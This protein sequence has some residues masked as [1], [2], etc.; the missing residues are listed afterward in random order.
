MKRR[1]LISIIATGTWFLGATLALAGADGGHDSPSGDG[2]EPLTQMAVYLK[3]DATGTGDGTCWTNAHTSV[4]NALYDAQAKGLPVYAAQGVYI[5]S[6][7]IPLPP[8]FA[9]YGG[10]PGLSMDETPADRAP[11][12]CQTIFS[13][14][15][16]QDDVWEHYEPNTSYGLDTTTLE[17]KVIVNGR[18][19]EPPPFTG[20]YDGY[21]PVLKGSNT[22]VAFVG[23]SSYGVMD[24]V[25]V[26]GFTTAGNSTTTYGAINLVSAS[27]GNYIFDNCRF[28]GNSTHYGVFYMRNSHAAKIWNCDF[29]YNWAL[30]RCG[31]ITV[32]SGTCGDNITN[33]T[34]LCIARTGADAGLVLNGWSGGF[35]VKDSR[36]VRCVQ[37]SGG[38][39]QSLYG[40]AGAIYCTE[41]G[42]T[43]YLLDCV[44]TN[45]FVATSNSQGPSFFSGRGTVH[46][47]R[48]LF[49]NNLA[50]CKPTAGKAFSMI[51]NVGDAGEA[52]RSFE[53][54]TFAG[55]LMRA[56][57]VAV[58]A[59]SYALGIIGNNVQGAGSMLL[60]CTFMTNMAET[61]VEKEGVT[62]V[63]C[64]GVLTYSS[65]QGQVDQTGLANCTFLGP[66]NGQYDIAQYGATHGYPLNIV[67][68]IFEADGDVQPEPVY[69]DV[70]SLVSFYNSSILNKFSTANESCT[71]EGLQFDKIPLVQDIVDTHNGRWALRPSAMVPGL[72][73]TCNVA[74]NGSTSYGWVFKRTTADATWQALAPNLNALSGSGF[75]ARLVDDAAG[76][77]RPSGSFTRGVLQTL[78]PTAEQGRSLVLRRDPYAGG[79]F[80]E[81]A[82]QSVAIG[83]DI[84]PVTA[85]VTDPDLYELDG[86]YLTNGT[87]V[88]TAA[89]LSGTLA[90]YLTDP[91]TIIVCKFEAAPVD[92]TLDLG[93]AGQFVAS[94]TS[95][96]TLSLT[97]GD[98]FPDIPAWTPDP[99]WVLEGFDTPAF[100]PAQATTYHARVVSSAVRIIHLVPEA[101]APAV[102]D[103][104]SW[105]TAYT[106]LATAYADAGRYRGEVWIK[107]GRYFIGTAVQMIPNVAVRGGFAGNETSADAADPASNLTILTGDR[108]G[109][110]YWQPNGS[111]DAKFASYRIWTN[112]V[113]GAGWTFNPPNPN[114][115]HN[116]W[117][118]GGNN[119]DDAATLFANS[120]ANCTNNLL[121]GLV[122]T[123]FRSGAIITSSGLADGFTA[124][125]CRFLAN[126][127]GLDG[128]EMAGVIRCS[129][130][131]MT[132]K[133]C[134]FHGN[135]YSVSA[136]SSS[137][138][139]FRFENCEFRDCPY[140]GSYSAGAFRMM[141]RACAIA[142]NTLF[143]R[144]WCGTAGGQGAA[145][146]S[147]RSTATH[148]FDDC[149]FEENRNTGDSHG[150]ICFSSGGSDAVFNR[151]KF[152]RNRHDN[153]GNSENSRGAC[154]GYYN[155][156]G[157]VMLRDCWFE[158]NYVRSTV[159]GDN[160]Y[161]ASV[162]SAIYGN[163]TFVNSTFLSN[164]N[165]TTQANICGT[166]ST[167]G[168]VAMINCAFKDTCLIG[169]S[170]ADVHVNGTPTAAIINTV[171]A[172]ELEGYVPLKCAD[173]NWVL[174]VANA[175]MQNLV[176]NGIAS[177]GSGYFYNVSTNGNPGFRARP[178]ERQGVSAFGLRAGSPY[179]FA[180]RPVW[181]SG[182]T[183][184][185]Y[186]DIHDAA[187]PW[188]KAIDR[189][190]TAA[191]V[192]GL[193]LQ[194][195]RIPDAF[196]RERPPRG[197]AYGPLNAPQ[198]G[199]VM[200]L[201]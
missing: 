66:Q 76:V 140:S 200:L 100:V 39:Y 185:F 13:G 52:Y 145:A 88:S 128:G 130:S 71:Y 121:D 157:T 191:S 120:S 99:A 83:D 28:V 158:G 16:G 41:G 201:R 79:T 57:E 160:Q 70:P 155:G 55:N 48:C 163:T 68:C 78:T 114:D 173:A 194:S 32:H 64:R 129:E 176:T 12:T 172:S 93:T 7:T 21:R 85:T 105:A 115:T 178:D 2:V 116:Y 40:G 8:G 186:D 131:G 95:Q 112:I 44:M 11:K 175:H 142:T 22:S 56:R 156:A 137:T 97:P 10:F 180:S 47:K 109:D 63:L 1:V 108:N 72:R 179:A 168:S 30:G 61:V 80:S 132:F 136:T 171:M 69:A 198:G 106:N 193:T 23:D 196:G 188:R 189:G 102:Q 147:L 148:S 29:T 37:A 81:A 119:G 195:P 25:V 98:V 34:F 26:S 182:T 18:I 144:C 187:K 43:C 4:S 197:F 135:W 122:I 86:W 96:I 190:S 62:P 5:I 84:V 20:M 17:E 24:G 74:T 92:I 152:I 31:A 138:R 42:S 107:K 166:I 150:T 183:V 15:K 149:I 118:P 91:V 104:A 167:S 36:I 126:N 27:G 177:S 50:E 46:M 49:A 65:V 124:S 154:I 9:V 165:E 101:E 153:T 111:T 181:L 54:C 162:L 146:V 19:N 117:R 133:D 192:T 75:E 143:H 164:T 161:P 103:G 3:A 35:T 82:S 38:F 123:C 113:E 139:Y 159:S 199:S 184:Y 77:A 33:C 94:G 134:L 59:G 174:T 51:A 45:N 89:T 60:N 53:S 110:D 67:N 58:T 169:E 125:R 6:N 170:A 73:E 87:C 141:G 90:D 127:T 14:D 151:C